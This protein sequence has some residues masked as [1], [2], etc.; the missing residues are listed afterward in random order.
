MSITIENHGPLITRTNWFD[1]PAA[2]QGVLAVSTNAGAV[3]LLIPRVQEAAIQEI[4]ACRHIVLSVG[5]WQKRTGPEALE[6]LFEDGTDAPFSIHVG[7]NQVLDGWPNT[8]QQG[9]LFTAW[10]APRRRDGR[11]HRAVEKPA[12]VRRSLTLPDLSPWEGV[13][14]S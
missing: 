7:T 13:A 11:P 10:T 2:A 9:W 4:T 8:L 1:S 3:R 12:F 5:P 6:L 14:E